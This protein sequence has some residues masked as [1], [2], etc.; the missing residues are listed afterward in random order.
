MWPKPL[1]NK[2][3][4]NSCLFCYC[5]V[6]D[7]TDRKTRITLNLLARILQVPFFN[8]LRT[9][10]QLGYAVQS[11]FTVWT[12]SVGIYFSIQ[13]ERDPAYCEARL[14]AFLETMTSYLQELPDSTFQEHKS[15]LVVL[16]EEKFQNLDDE[17]V[18]FWQ[19]IRSGYE[20]FRT[21]QCS[22]FVYKHVC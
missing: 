10:E 20:E 4:L 17:W 1:A 15:G 11:G 19:E 22:K 18:Y 12:A 8:Q 9:V 3:E 14:D 2:D 13:S 21:S 6:G 16:L 5:H 7:I